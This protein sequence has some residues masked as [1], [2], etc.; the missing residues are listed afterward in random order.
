MND[1]GFNWFAATRVVTALLHGNS[2]IIILRIC[3]NSQSDECDHSD[4][5]S[6]ARRQTNKQTQ[7]TPHKC[8]CLL[9]MMWSASFLDLVLGVRRHLAFFLS[10]FFQEK[11]KRNRASCKSWKMAAAAVLKPL[12]L[13]PVTFASHTLTHTHVALWKRRTNHWARSPPDRQDTSPIHSGAV[14]SRWTRAVWTWFNMTNTF[15]LFH[16]SIRFLEANEA[17]CTFLKCFFKT[18]R[19]IIRKNDADNR[20]LP[21]VLPVWLTHSCLSH[22]VQPAAA[23]HY[24]WNRAPL[25]PVAAVASERQ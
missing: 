14:H 6:A 7:I 20:I 24:W 9:A 15:Y 2:A 22:R 12:S 8:P 19:W 10:S 5:Q 1:D 25:W 18:S 13:T 23:W 3:Q 21:E 17:F 16:P 4:T 11:R